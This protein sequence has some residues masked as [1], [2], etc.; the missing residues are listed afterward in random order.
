MEIYISDLFCEQKRLMAVRSPPLCLLHMLK[1]ITN[2]DMLYAID[3]LVILALARMEFP[4]FRPCKQEMACWNLEGGCGGTACLFVLGRY[5][6][7][8][9]A[10]Y[11]LYPDTIQLVEFFDSVHKAIS[12]TTLERREVLDTVR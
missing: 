11:V 7:A 6:D 3:H 2:N 1:W 5:Q 10:E 12:L 9:L 8:S 4:Y